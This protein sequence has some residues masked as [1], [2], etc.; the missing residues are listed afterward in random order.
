MNITGIKNRIDSGIAIADADGDGEVEIYAT[1]L[2]GKLVSVTSTGKSKWSASLGGRSR[3][4][5]T[6][7]DVDGDGIV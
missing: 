2:A 3:R 6:I 5:P 4:S 7:A 1:N